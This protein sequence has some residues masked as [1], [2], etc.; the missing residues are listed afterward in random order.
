MKNSI[1]EFIETHIEL[2]ER[3]DF[4]TLYTIAENTFYSDSD[5]FALTK[6]F[7][8]CDIYPELSL[9]ILPLTYVDYR[10]DFEKY[11]DTYPM[12]LTYLTSRDENHKA[13]KLAKVYAL[14][15]QV[16]TIYNVENP[17]AFIFNKKTEPEYQY[18]KNYVTEVIV[19]DTVTSIKDHMFCQSPKLTKVHLGAKVK[20][21]G[22]EAFCQC[23]ALIDIN[24]PSSLKI[25]GQNSF[26]Q[27]GLTE[28]II[29]PSVTEIRPGAFRMSQIRKITFSPNQKYIDEFMCSSC[30]N[31]EEVIIPEG[32]ETIRFNAFNGCVN[33]G[34]ITFPDSLK[35]IAESAFRSCSFLISINTNQVTQIGGNAFDFCMSLVDVEIPNV[36]S[37]A[38]RV[39]ACC[40]SLKEITIPKSCKIVGRDV[41]DGCHDQLVVSYYSEVA[42]KFWSKDWAK[43]IKTRDLSEGD[44]EL[45]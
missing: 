13:V 4:E 27:T 38:Q 30:S 31:L 45:S 44:H 11:L 8:D 2:I 19:E 42:D 15:K 17:P 6:A 16:Q 41:F 34:G 26:Y 21:I 18:A 3:E 1:K 12:L 32:I 24:F 22:S 10:N 23:H 7:H 5:I 14:K 25:I 39:F 35:I 29:P 20:A 28:V 36:V 37:I 33:L 9:K 43:K 40:K